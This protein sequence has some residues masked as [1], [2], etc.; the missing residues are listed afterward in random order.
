M[1]QMARPKLDMALPYKQYRLV[2]SEGRGV[3]RQDKHPFC[4]SRVYYSKAERPEEVWAQDSD[5]C[6]RWRQ[7]SSELKVIALKVPMAGFELHVREEG[8]GVEEKVARRGG[9]MSQDHPSR[10]YMSTIP[11]GPRKCLSN[12]PDVAYIWHRCL[13]I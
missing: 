3:E 4:M 5:S 10:S 1:M 13:R 11:S 12:G 8:P 7:T 9:G 6:Y 2:T